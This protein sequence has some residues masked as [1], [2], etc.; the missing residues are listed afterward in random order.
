MA[1]ATGVQT[2]LSQVCFAC[3][4]LNFVSCIHVF[5]SGSLNSG[6]RSCCSIKEVVVLD[7]VAFSVV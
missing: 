5:D 1:S 2:S 7:T 6:S 4:T 3:I